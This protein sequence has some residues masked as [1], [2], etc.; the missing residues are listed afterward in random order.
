MPGFRWTSKLQQT[1]ALRYVPGPSKACRDFGL[2]VW[3]VTVLRASG[4][5]TRACNL[6]T[7]IPACSI[8]ADSRPKVQS[9]Q[10]SE[11]YELTIQAPSWHQQ[12][13]KHKASHKST[14]R[15]LMWYIEHGIEYM[16]CWESR[17]PCRC[18][19]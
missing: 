19:C 4:K 9:V 2:Y 18:Q 14:K 15:I 7:E 13:Q 11:A 3:T 1:V 16:S 5:S 10:P 8:R 6:V 12:A 17:R